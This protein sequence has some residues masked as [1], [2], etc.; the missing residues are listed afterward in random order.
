VLLIH[1]RGA[2][3]NTFTVETIEQNLVQYLVH[4]GYEPWVLDLRTSIGLASSKRDWTFDQT[5]LGDIPA[6]IDLVRQWTRRE[7]VDVV[8]HCIGAA[9]FCMAALGGRL[10][11]SPDHPLRALAQ[12]YGRVH[13]RRDG[14]PG[15]Y[16]IRQGDWVRAA[17]LSQVGPLLELP[18]TNRFRGY[19]ASYFKHYLE[20]G[21]F[22]TTAS[23]IGFNRFLDRVLGTYPYPPNEWLVHQPE[24]WS[25]LVT[26]EAFCLRAYGIYGRLFEHNQ[27]NDDTLAGLG[28]Y[29][30]HIRYRTYQQ[31]IFYATMRR[32]TDEQGR[33]RF[34]R[35]D[36]IRQYL[37]FPLCFLH[38][39][40]NE[41]FAK[42]TSRRSFDLLASVL[43]PEDLADLW[44]QKPARR[45]GY[46]LFA[47]G[48]HLR[49]HEL[50]TYGHQDTMIG[51]R[52]QPWRRA[53]V[54]T[55]T[56]AARPRMSFSK[57]YS[58]PYMPVLSRPT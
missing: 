14:S 55:T 18:P 57:A 49:L 11:H 27:L 8:A 19:L 53:S 58:I 1:G 31:T 47:R 9:M 7:Q 28:D 35:D 44:Q 15:A 36:R 22:D 38:G 46:T 43:W 26:H 51:R 12:S 40:K 3:G 21:E 20:I 10:R 41:V 42:E 25:E 34:V 56:L 29:L 32:L 30:G 5:A 16:R 48:R 54:C 50:H 39:A 6:A 23:L 45:S 52:A 17:V 33:N 13:V 4:A 2:G 37:S 24:H